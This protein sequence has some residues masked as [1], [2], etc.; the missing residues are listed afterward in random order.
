MKKLIYSALTLALVLTATPVFA[1]SGNGS[2]TV[3]S[4][5][6]WF[7]DLINGTLVPLIFALAF[8][9]FL[10]GVF[11]FFF[12]S[13]KNAEENRQE[14]K[15]FI[16]W[17]IIAFAI[18]ICVWGLVN[19]LVRTIP[20]LENETRPCLPTFSGPCNSSSGSPRGEPIGM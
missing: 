3:N 9:L 11:K 12:G 19:I 4:T 16:L 15:K 5:L 1:Q 20:G 8:L 10:F 14:G 2:D 13:G 18:M 6:T 17:A 7:I